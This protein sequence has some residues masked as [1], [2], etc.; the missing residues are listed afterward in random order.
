MSPKSRFQFSIRTLFLVV[1]ASAMILWQYRE[2]TREE[3]AITRIEALGGEVTFTCSPN[4]DRFAS[5]VLQDWHGG[6]DGLALLSS[7]RNLKELH[8]SSL[9]F[10][11]RC[12]RMLLQMESLTI[13][14]LDSTGVTD[15][16]IASLASVQTLRHLSLRYTKITGQGFKS[17]SS[18]PIQSLDLSDTNTDDDGLMYIGHCE[19]LQVLRLSGCKVTDGAI[20]EMPNLKHLHQLDLSK[21]LVGDAVCAHLGRCESLEFLD[22]EDT[23]VGNDGIQFLNLHVL[24]KVVVRGSRVTSTGL[25]GLSARFP[26]VIMGLP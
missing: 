15:Q 20:V 19:D 10:D 16:G 3:R 22:L 18:H 6:S 14:S 24:T 2:L 21:T 12:I 1:T 4:A 23:C 9:E 13:L 8:V 5:V 17:F 26:G 7:I 25:Q 11:D